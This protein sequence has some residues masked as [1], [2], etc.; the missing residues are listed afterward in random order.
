MQFHLM[1]V[2]SFGAYSKGDVVSD[3]DAIG[4]ILAGENAAHVVRIAVMQ[5]G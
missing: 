5:G 3:A 1:V 4:A 2:R